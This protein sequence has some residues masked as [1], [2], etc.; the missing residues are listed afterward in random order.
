MGLIDQG[1]FSAANFLLTVSVARYS[2]PQEFGAFAVLF[3]SY[4]IA[5]MVIRGMTADV[6]VVHSTGERRTSDASVCLGAV[7]PL[8]L[9][10]APLLMGI[11]WIVGGN[12]PNLGLTFALAIPVLAMQDC[13]RYI[14][15]A[16]Q[17]P[18]LAIVNDGTVL[19]LQAAI[20]VC[21]VVT[22]N[23][24]PL[25]F[26]LAWSFG[27]LC[28]GSLA[29][30]F[31]KIVPRLGD[32]REW[33]KSS[34]GLSVRYGLD[35]LIAQ[36]TSQ[37]AL[38]VIAGVAGLSASGAFRAAQTLF[39]PAMVV[40]VGAM[41]AVTPELV[42][43]RRLSEGRFRTQ[44][45]RLSLGLAVFGSVVSIVILALPNHVGTE[46]FG[47]TWMEAVPLLPWLAVVQI[48]S[49][50]RMGAMAGLRATADAKLT[51]KARWRVTVLAILAPSLGAFMGGANGAAMLLAA[52]SVPQAA[53]WWFYFRRA[54]A[55]RAVTQPRRHRTS[56]GTG[57]STGTGN[58]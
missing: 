7:V 31:L 37:V 8:A 9:S 1:L 32:G 36:S 28:G 43:I 6:Y 26:L 49:G 52:V 30:L 25:L 44:V 34:G 21:L 12:G 55:Y 11:G 46:V 17:R 3:A 19:I 27:T 41:A 42:R 50:V 33:I 4:L 51:L 23:T 58:G 2:S 35:N 15:L 10:A 56:E 14:A 20:S 24:D 57:V 45:A 18:F 47:P 13:L 54:F 16:N 39:G 38:F 53:I 48:M 40:V 22:G 5:A 29:M